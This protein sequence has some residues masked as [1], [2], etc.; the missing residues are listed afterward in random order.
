MT[1][2]FILGA[3]GFGKEILDFYNDLGREEDVLGFLDENLEIA[4]KILNKKKVYHIS[5]LNDYKP[6]DVKLVCGI[7]IPSKNRT[8][9]IEKTKKM[10][11]EYE[12]IIHPSVIVSKWVEIGEG[13]IICAGSII[14]TQVKIGDFSIVNINCTVAH[15]IVIGNYSTL[16][17][18]THISGNVT[19]GDECFFGTGAVT[20]QGIEVGDNSV[21]GAGAVLTESI[22]NFSLAVGVPAKVIK[23]LK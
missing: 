1:K 7:G 16:S 6:K 10:G 8:K 21:I 5:K 13:S 12:T 15:D 3:G 19:I 23:K 2:V 17:P 14:T 11:F 9:I 20:V 18:G 22:D 4:G